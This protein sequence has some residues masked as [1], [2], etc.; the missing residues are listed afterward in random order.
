MIQTMIVITHIGADTTT[1]T[2]T[3]NNNTNNNAN[4]K[5]AAVCRFQGG[6]R[7]RARRNLFT[8][9]QGDGGRV[10]SGV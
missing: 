6:G 7:H 1:T 9:Q 10:G 2:T 3:N 8:P 5:H 4:N